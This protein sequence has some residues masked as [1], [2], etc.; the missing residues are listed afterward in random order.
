VFYPKRK[1]EIEE[2]C[3][4]NAHSNIPIPPGFGLPIGWFAYLIKGYCP[5]HVNHFN[6]FDKFFD[7]HFKEIVISLILYFSWLLCLLQYGI[8]MGFVSLLNHH[9]IPVMVF[10]G[11]IVI[12]TFLHHN[13]TEIGW[14]PD[15]EWNYVKG[16]LSTIDRHYGSIHGV[17]HNIGTHQIH[18]LFTSIPHYNLEKATI[19]FRNKFPHLVHIKNENIIFQ[20]FN[21]F[22]IY[23]KQ[24]MID[25][26]K[27]KDFKA[28]YYKN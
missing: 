25:D 15:S 20:F 13:E 6:P 18:H 8:L 19:A 26:I 12:I 17:I 22:S 4:N 28:Y 7:G 10:G 3:E 21:M 9:I 23:M 11:Y 14:Y 27:E 5:R 16:Q 24:H 1:S 2:K